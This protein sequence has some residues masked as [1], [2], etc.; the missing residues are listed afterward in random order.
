MKTQVRRHLARL[1]FEEKIS[2]VAQL[3]QLATK[4][5]EQRAAGRA[6]YAADAAAPK[7]AREKPL[8]YGPL[9]DVLADPG[10]S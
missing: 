3:I 6:E 4:L 7:K 10:K 1:P 9:K 2:R 8:H 5:K